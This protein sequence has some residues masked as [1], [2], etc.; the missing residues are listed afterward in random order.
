[1]ARGHMAICLHQGLTKAQISALLDIVERNLG[2]D[3][4]APLRKV[5]DSLNNQ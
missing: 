2:A 1:M 4:V 5:L 3:S